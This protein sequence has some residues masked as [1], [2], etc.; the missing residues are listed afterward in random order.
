MASSSTAKGSSASSSSSFDSSG[1]QWEYEVFLSFRGEDTRHTFTDHLY[2][3]LKDRGIC[4]F[5]DDEGLERGKEISSELLE[6]IERSRFSIIVLSKNYVSSTWCLKELAK[7]LECKDKKK[8]KVFPVFYKV[9]PSD[10]GNQ[11]GDFETAFHKHEEDYKDNPDKVQ[12]WRSALT[13]VENLSGWHLQEGREWKV[14]PTLQ[15]NRFSHQFHIQLPESEIPKWFRCRS[16]GD[17]VAI[18]LRPN[19]LNDEFMGIA[20][21]G[22]YAPDPVDLNNGIERISIGMSIMR[23]DYAFV[24]DT[25]GFTSVESNYLCLTFV[26]RVMFEHDYSY[27]I[28]EEDTSSEYKSSDDVPCGSTCIHARFSWTSKVIKCGIRLVYKQDIEDFQELMAA[29]GSTFHQNHNCSLAEG[30]SRCWCRFF[31]P[32]RLE[33]HCNTRINYSGSGL[34]VPNYARPEHSDGDEEPD[35]AKKRRPRRDGIFRSI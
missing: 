19:W 8:Q 35:L 15:V 1:I 25:P 27:K 10:I 30:R 7:I 22:V 17:S 32:T 5:R 12:K 9:D 4:T 11:S 26:S 3:A 23:N 18:E 14:P 13:K 6:T 34:G 2:T 21:C 33:Y 20:I 29:E 31:M 28:T 24:F 16:E